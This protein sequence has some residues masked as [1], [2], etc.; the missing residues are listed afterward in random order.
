VVNDVHPAKH[1]FRC[2]ARFSLEGYMS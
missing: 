2:Q 1:F